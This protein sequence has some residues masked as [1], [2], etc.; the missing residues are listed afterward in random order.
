MS[1]PEPYFRD[2]NSYR[3][4]ICVRVG[5]L[6]RSVASSVIAACEFLIFL[7]SMFFVSGCTIS[8]HTRFD[9]LW[10]RAVAVHRF[11]TNHSSDIRYRRALLDT[12]EF[13]DNAFAGIGEEAMMPLASKKTNSHH[14]SLRAP[15]TQVG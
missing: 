8:Q 11:T 1:V 13:N 12:S 9:G 14:W 6:K 3:A 7:P 4:D 5:P 15:C 10:E 2:R